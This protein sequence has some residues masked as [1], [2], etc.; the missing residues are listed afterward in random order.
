METK[1]TPNDAYFELKLWG[2]HE[3]QVWPAGKLAIL[4]HPHTCDIESDHCQQRLIKYIEAEG[5]FDSIPSKV[6]LLDSYIEDSS[7][8][9]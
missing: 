8:Q 3:L 5:L 9:D 1:P 2:D 6:L 7:K 4:R